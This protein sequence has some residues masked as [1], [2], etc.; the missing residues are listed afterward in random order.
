MLIC[1]ESFGYDT[2]ESFFRQTGEWVIPGT[3]TCRMM[4]AG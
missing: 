1:I 4:I 3:G 2:K